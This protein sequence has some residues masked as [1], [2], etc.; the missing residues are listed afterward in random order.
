MG[1]I[2]DQYEHL[3]RQ[4]EATKVLLIEESNLDCN[5]PASVFYRGMEEEDN[6]NQLNTN[7]NE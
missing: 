4:A 1:Y 7:K 5:D 3:K 2:Q 6:T